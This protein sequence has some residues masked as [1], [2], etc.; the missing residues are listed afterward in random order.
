MKLS[1]PELRSRLAAEYVLGT[2]HGAARRRFQTYLERDA[3]LRAEVNQWQARLV[4]LI[5]VVTP[6]EP[7]RRVWQK[8]EARLFDAN[9]TQT[10][11]STVVSTPNAAKRGSA[12]GLFTWLTSRAGL[13]FAASALC[14]ML[15]VLLLVRQLPPYDQPM[16]VAVLEDT[17][18][19]RMV[20]EQNKPQLL[21]VRMVKPW[22]ANTS[23][24]FQL[25]ILP[26]DGAPRSIGLINQDGSTKIEMK[27]L[28]GLL[29]G[30][31]AFAVTREAKGGSVTGQPT[32][33]ILCKGVIA[34]TPPR[35][36]NRSANK[37]A[38]TI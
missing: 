19:A 23:S 20:I 32:M 17:S 27:E 16:R 11:A 30:G 34:K 10:Q 1:H 12:S 24:S 22:K 31:L 21:E 26:P 18:G 14:G 9:S 8:I 33:P 2:M 35:E 6:I 29:E 13:T 5:D 7:P 38:N 15:A 37:P 36:A 25:W 3:A 28:E 4:P